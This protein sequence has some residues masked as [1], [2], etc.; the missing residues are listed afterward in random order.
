MQLE[1]CWLGHQTKASDLK[2]VVPFGGPLLSLLKAQAMPYLTAAILEHIC[3]NF[4]GS[5]LLNLC[6]T[7]NQIH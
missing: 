1:I 4:H 3:S 7:L 6:H 2:F 5:L